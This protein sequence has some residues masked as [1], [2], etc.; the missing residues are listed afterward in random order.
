MKRKKTFI[1]ITDACYVMGAEEV[2]GDIFTNETIDEQSISNYLCSITTLKNK[3][4]VISPN[5][6]IIKGYITIVKRHIESLSLC[7]EVLKLFL[8][9]ADYKVNSINYL[10]YMFI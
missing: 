9:Y 4:F 5:K 1:E 3:K 6:E 8:H 2:I 7:T 10:L